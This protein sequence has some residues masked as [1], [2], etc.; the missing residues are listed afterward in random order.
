VIYI[1]VQQHGFSQKNKQRAYRQLVVQQKNIVHSTQPFPTKKM[2]TTQTALEMCGQM[3]TKLRLEKQKKQ[4][5]DQIN[6]LLQTKLVTFDW[7]PI[8]RKVDI[9]F[10]NAEHWLQEY[11][12]QGNELKNLLNCWSKILVTDADKLLNATDEQKQ[13]Q[14]QDW[15][16]IVSLAV[17]LA[18]VIAVFIWLVGW[19]SMANLFTIS[20]FLGVIFTVLAFA[21]N[22][23]GMKPENLRD[24]K[25]CA[26]NK[27]C[28]ANYIAKYLAQR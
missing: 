13:K 20:V 6:E 17:M 16:L 1:G 19:I 7:E 4:F 10:I 26:F 18:Q 9:I 24:N 22:G 8:E 15:L 25:L 12:C 28:M 3:D 21:Y 5:R 27:L 23:A 2:E 11:N 14:G